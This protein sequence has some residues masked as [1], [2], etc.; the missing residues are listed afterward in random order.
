MEEMGYIAFEI[1]FILR[2]FIHSFSGCVRRLGRYG[3]GYEQNGMGSVA[4]H[5]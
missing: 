1:S 4:L 3:Y 5:I 2:S